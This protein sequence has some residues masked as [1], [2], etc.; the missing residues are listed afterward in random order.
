ML[1][2]I[3]KWQQQAQCNFIGENNWQ[4]NNKF[5]K[6]NCFSQQYSL[7]VESKS[8]LNLPIQRNKQTALSLHPQSSHPPNY[9]PPWPINR[10]NGKLLLLRTRVRDPVRI[11][12]AHLLGT[13]ATFMLLEVSRSTLHTTATKNQKSF[14]G[15]YA[16][17]FTGVWDNTYYLKQF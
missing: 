4:G 5:R 13:Q 6:K 8:P 1:V 9:F 2:V 10:G 15:K 7:G 17:A 12:A 14:W 3:Q 16:A 11:S